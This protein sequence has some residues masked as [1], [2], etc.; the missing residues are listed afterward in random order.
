M[1]PRGEGGVTPWTSAQVYRANIL[2]HI[3]TV[4]QF[5]VTSKS[6]VHRASFDCGRNLENPCREGEKPLMFLL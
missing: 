1:L 5:R 6:N 2:T 3:H 4:G